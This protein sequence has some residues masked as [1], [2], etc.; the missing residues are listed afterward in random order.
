[1]SPKEMKYKDNVAGNIF[2]LKQLDNLGIDRKYTGFY[3]LV[4][5]MQVLINEEKR[6]KSFSKQ[7]YPKIAEK[8]GKTNC[9]VERNIRNLIEHCWCKEMMI[10]LNT[11]FP[12]GK[13]PTCG[14][15]VYLIKNYIKEQIM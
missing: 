6:I 8:Y 11:F 7:V 14:E 13:R 9:T 12:E 2:F 3:L 4:E 15:F 1:M 10:Q 5:I